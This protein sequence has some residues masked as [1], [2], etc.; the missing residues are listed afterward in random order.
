[1]FICR[2]W[3]MFSFFWDSPGISYRQNIK[4]SHPYQLMNGSNSFYCCADITNKRMSLKNIMLVKRCQ[5][6]KS[7]YHMIPLYETLEKINVFYS[8]RKQISD[9]LGL[10][11]GEIDRERGWKKYSAFGLWC[12]LHGGTNFQDL[13]KLFNK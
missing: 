9:Y 12:W 5:A 4:N 11:L 7:T 3:A 6:R 2:L 13:V 8:D 10:S 1:M